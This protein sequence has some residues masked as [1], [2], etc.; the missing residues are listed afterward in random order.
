MSTAN[1]FETS[2][3][4]GPER[5]WAAQLNRAAKAFSEKTA[6][7]FE[8]PDWIY[9]LSFAQWHDASQEVARSLVAIGIQK[10]DKV[11]VMA[12]GGPVWPLVQLA[13]SSIE[14]T[15]VPLNLRY[16]A[17]ELEYVLG[18]CRPKALFYLR[19]LRSNHIGVRVLDALKVLSNPDA[20]EVKAIEL[21]DSSLQSSP[22]VPIVTGAI[23]WEDFIQRSGLGT[24]GSFDDDP[25]SEEVPGILQFTSGTTSFPKGALLGQSPTL[26]VGFHLGIRLGLTSEDVLYS[27]QPFYHVGGSITTVLVALMHGC[28]VVAPERYTP[29]E[30]FR[31]IEKYACT[32]RYGQGAMY[33]MELNHPDFRPEFFKSVTKGWAVGSPGLLRR[34][35]EE[36]GIDHLIQLYGLTEASGVSAST[37]WQDSLD[38]RLGSC[39][40]PFPGIVITIRNEGGEDLEQDQDGEIC[41]KGW[42][43]MD[44]YLIVNDSSPIPTTDSA[45]WLHTGDLGRVDA[46]GRLY[47]VDRLKDMIKP[48]GENVSA[49]EVE[50]VLE[51]H[52]S[53]KQASVVG[54]EDERLGEVP[55]AFV[56]V[57]QGQ[58]CSDIDL[59]EYCRQRMADF[60]VPRRINFVTGWPMTESG[61]VQKKVLRDSSK[62]SPSMSSIGKS[63]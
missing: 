8:G 4:V 37:D 45:G 59:I 62:V 52:P 55:I 26:Q 46:Q 51:E 32:A 3:A 11:A 27:T 19:E 30:T 60:K 36:M 6:F 12:P 57:R 10:G 40:K 2:E 43:L 44:G 28:T 17:D 53:V 23:G 35:S 61:K 58:D 48:G 34:I 7:I 47:F 5:R 21:A 49:A 42:G 31:L 22:D 15:L 29:A 54:A 33:A 1:L 41:I 9:R 50:R 38:D 25:L 24:F 14:A 16:Q 18:A 39:G 63:G 56:E 20:W 13:C